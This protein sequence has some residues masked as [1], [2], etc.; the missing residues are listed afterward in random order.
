MHRRRHWSCSSSQRKRPTLKPDIQLRTK[1]S[2]VARTH[3]CDSV[4]RCWAFDV[5]CSAFSAKLGDVE[6]TEATAARR[7]RLQIASAEAA[8]ANEELVGRASHDVDDDRRYAALDRSRV[9]DR[10]FLRVHAAVSAK[11]IIVDRCGMG[12]SLQQSRSRYRSYAARRRH[13]GDAGDLCCRVP[14]W[15]LDTEST[16][17]AASTFSPVSTARLCALARVFTRRLA[18]F[19]ARVHWLALLSRTVSYRCL[20]SDAVA[21]QPR[22]GSADD[23]IGSE[24]VV[25]NE[26][27][28]ES[29][30][31]GGRSV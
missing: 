13:L 20:F 23:S 21:H 8:R 6:T 27:S 3:A 22:Q 1:C 26:V 18:D 5:G 29:A 31:P 30:R 14:V 16:C 4:I 11:D 19:L 10:N 7:A 9:G 2:I 17:S 15:L 12:L 28:M 25:L 24:H